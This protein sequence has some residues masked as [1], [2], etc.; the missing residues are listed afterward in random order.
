M[1]NFACAISAVAL[2]ACALGPAQQPVL[3][4]VDCQ[5]FCSAEAAQEFYELHFEHAIVLDPDMNG[6]AC[7]SAVEKRSA[8]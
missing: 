4:A 8:K 3:A 7:D 1:R 2:S 6:V 5:R